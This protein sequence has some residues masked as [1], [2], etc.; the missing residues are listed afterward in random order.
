[1]L[2]M[3][4]HDTLQQDLLKHAAA[5]ATSK[6]QAS[7]TRERS[8]TPSPTDLHRS[9]WSLTFLLPGVMSGRRACMR[10]PTI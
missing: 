8:G 10:L 4:V 3:R 6:T 9:A 2:L 5:G 1:M 7:R